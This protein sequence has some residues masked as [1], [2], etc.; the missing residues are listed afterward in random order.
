[1]K[2]KSIV[3]KDMNKSAGQNREERPA[4]MGPSNATSSG[5]GMA[6]TSLPLIPRD[7]VA[8]DAPLAFGIAF[9][10][11]IEE[12]DLQWRDGLGIGFTCQDPDLWHQRK[13]P[14]K[15]AIP[16]LRTCTVGYG[17]R[18]FCQG[19]SEIL[20]GAWEP[21]KLSKGDLVTAVLVGAPANVMRVL[22]NGKVVTQRALK[23]CGLPD[24]T[25]EQLWGIV[26][27]ESA[28]VKV[29]LG[30]PTVQLRMLASNSRAAGAM[31]AF[32]AAKF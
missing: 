6:I 18:W 29:R 26:D 25:S 30:L 28:C 15:N 1:F 23:D 3:L 13:P 16:L 12:T 32:S 11:T 2:S 19:K 20:R 27:V 9:D 22:V 10:I 21:G 5:G 31:G 8:P 24:P 7:G 17:G 4:A 14:P